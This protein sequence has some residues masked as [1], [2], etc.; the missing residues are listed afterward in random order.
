MWLKDCLLAA[1]VLLGVEAQTKT[2]RQEASGAAPSED[3]LDIREDGGYGFRYQARDQG[4][5]YGEGAASPDNTVTGKFGYRDPGSGVNVETRYTA[6]E[7]GFRAQGPLV[8]RRMDL[9]Q[10]KLPYNPPVPPDSPDYNPSYSTY[11]DPNEDSSYHFDFAT[12]EYKRTETGGPRGEVAGAYSYVDDVGDIHNVEFE[13][14]SQRGFH[15]KTPYPDSNHN[16]NELYFRGDGRV[17]LRGRTSIQRGLDGSYKFTTHS[18]DQRRSEVKD[19]LGNTKGSYT[20]IDKDGTQRSVQYVAGPNIGYKII[21]Q[22]LGASLDPVFPYIHQNYIPSNLQ[23][24]GSKPGFGSGGPSLFGDG[25]GGTKPFKGPTTTPF[26]FDSTPSTVGPLPPSGGY[27][28]GSY[29][30]GGG[31]KGVGSGGGSFGG[32]GGGSGGGSFGAGGSGGGGGTGGFGDKGGTFGSGAIG[33]SLGGGGGS[34]GSGGS[35]YR[36]AAGPCC[37]AST[38]KGPRPSPTPRPESPPKGPGKDEEP[39]YPPSGEKP[40]NGL[41]DPLFTTSDKKPIASPGKPS[42]PSSND[43]FLSPTSGYPP[44]PHA[45]FPEEDPKAKKQNNPNFKPFTV[46]DNLFLQ[47]PFSS[48]PPAG[49]E[50]KFNTDRSDDFGTESSITSRPEYVDDFDRDGAYSEDEFTGFPPGVSVKGRIQSLDINPFGNKVPAPGEALEFN[51]GDEERRGSY[52]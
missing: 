38:D 9:S 28:Q 25:S 49:R 7:R 16:Y 5:H 18:Q 17:P 22:G 27:G 40:L 6:G 14:D 23:G 13:A 12:Q 52:N 46:E 10:I 42:K 8:H 50:S 29:G 19:A 24:A 35:V 51:I 1:V 26:G 37:A 39:P 43:D 21:N 41:K 15:V 32:V 30:S 45:G 44:P 33:G 36:P 20:Y 31:N 47:R 34:Y 3:V 11:H 4:G 2:A 48:L